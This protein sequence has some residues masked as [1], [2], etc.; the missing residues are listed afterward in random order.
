MVE[1]VSPPKIEEF[2]PAETIEYL[3]ALETQ[4]VSVWRPQVGP[5]VAFHASPADELLY[6]GAAGGGKSE[7][8]LV[9]AARHIEVPGYHA[10]ILRRTFPELTRSDGLIPRSKQYFY[11][12]GKWR[13]GEYR[14][15]FNT[16]TKSNPATIDFGHLERLDDI[17]K[18]QSAA[19]AY[20]A[21]DELTSFIEEQYIY[22]ISRLRSK[23]QVSKRLRSA[24]NPGN[25]GH[26]WVFR[27]WG[28][29]LD[30][31]HYNPAKSGEIR[32]FARINDDDIEVEADWRG[33]DG[34]EPLSRSFI[35]AFVTDNP[36][37]LTLDP[38][39]LARLAALPEPYRSQLR[40]GNWLVG[41]E[42]EWQVIPH[43][44][45]R[46][47]MDRWEPRAGS[48]FDFTCCACDPAR[49]TDNAV[50]GYR[51]GNWVGELVYRRERDTMYLIGEISQVYADQ[52]ANGLVS[53]ARVDVIGV[54]AGVYDRMREIAMEKREDPERKHE[55][56]EAIPI[57]AGE[58]TTATDKSGQLDI[59]NVRAEMWWHMR[60]LLD[61]DNPLGL[62]EPVALPPDKTLLA[63]LTAPRWRHTSG[64]ILI[65]SKLDIKKRIGR[66]TDAGDTVC[67]LFY[68]LGGIG[69]GRGG[70]WV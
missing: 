32:Y 20:I 36:A 27:R 5:Q 14:W 26:D 56:I 15:Y 3:K 11:D 55:I 24:T 35:P 22:L 52:G 17:H 38:G 28:A 39:Y 65:E 41:K 68:E 69:S 63:D 2:I 48:G 25:E 23:A 47:A 33:A 50:V 44:W 4:G 6:G 62:T 51:R 37:L 16:K 40:D 29:W 57:N 19:Y 21:F 9:E 10:L 12:L 30:P 66:S 49:G 70:I 45:V 54:G 13:A 64:G 67:M 53:P 1:T 60:E 46:A 61:P 8:I 31:T 43:Q 7:S 42:H 34:E 18:Y 58:K 59:V